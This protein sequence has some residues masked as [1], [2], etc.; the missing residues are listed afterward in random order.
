MVKRKYSV[1]KMVNIEPMILELIDVNDLNWSI[2]QDESSRQ[3]MLKTLMTVSKPAELSAKYYELERQ[4]LEQQSE[5]KVLV[6]AEEIDEALM[7]NVYIIKGDITAI[8]SDAIVN[9]ANEQLLGCFV[10]GHHCI[11][12]AIQM[13]SG[14]GVR[15]DCNKIIEVQGYEEAVGLAKMTK[16]YNLPA[17]Y[18]IH[19][20][21]PNVH[22]PERLTMDQ[23]EEQLR[24]CYTSIL[25]EANAHEDIHNIVFCSISTGVYGV[26]IEL[27]SEIALGTIKDYLRTE[28]HHLERVII[29]VFSEEDY[30]T[31]KRKAEKF[32]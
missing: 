4:Y 9:A 16:G 30:V 18:I 8:E 13:A 24:S 31:Y 23:V 19:T 5:H 6:K 14:L 12:N 7:E 29:D 2:P 3:E 21:G 22:G 32:K 1:D 26:P 10:P 25:I 27:A 15:N 28:E 20:V 11:D 17:K